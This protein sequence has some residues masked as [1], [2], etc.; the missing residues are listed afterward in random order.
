M[1]LIEQTQKSKIA[2]S[3]RQEIGRVMH[4][5]FYDHYTIRK[6]TGYETVIA[7]PKIESSKGGIKN[8][9]EYIHASTGSYTLNMK[10]EDKEKAVPVIAGHVVEE[11]GL[12]IIVGH[13]RFPK[14]GEFHEEREKHEYELIKFAF[15]RG[16]PILAICGGSW[17][18][19]KSFGGELAEVEGHTASNMP[20]ILEDGSIGNNPQIHDIEL[21]PNTILKACMGLQSDASVWERYPMVNSVHWAAPVVSPEILQMFEVSAL[22][23]DSIEQ[24]VSFTSNTIEAFEGKSGAPTIGVLWHPEAYFK[25]TYT[26]EK[27]HMACQR[28]LNI[29]KYMAKSGDAYQAKQVMLRQ[30]KNEIAP[31][32]RKTQEENEALR[33]L[34]E[35]VKQSGNRFS[36]WSN[37]ASYTEAWDP[38]QMFI[39]FDD[40]KLH[41]IQLQ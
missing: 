18:L 12:L 28:H 19:W 29:L 14:P 15:L 4:A 37:L 35:R 33:C 34:K 20:T 22:S 16:Q 11:C 6:A 26:D 8:F 40:C 41:S 39:G 21:V 36:F 10:P 30:F 5:A 9:E 27:D 31:S 17:K 38:Q 2:I 1:P 13:R 32:L 24:R 25:T 7:V 3:F 23:K